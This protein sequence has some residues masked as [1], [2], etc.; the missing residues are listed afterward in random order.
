L[1]VPARHLE[2][3]SMRFPRICG[4]TLAVFVTVAAGAAMAQDLAEDSRP[5]SMFASTMKATVLDPTTYAPATVLYGSML[6]DWKSSQPFFAHGF[7]EANPRYTRNGLPYDVP[8]SYEAGKRQIL[9]DSLVTL[10]GMIAN[11]AISHLMERTLI[12]SH[13]EHRKLFRVLGVIQRVS[14]SAFI[15]YRLSAGHFQQWQKNQRLAAQLGY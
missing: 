3:E 10:P 1:A 13:P 4:L 2:D 9:K 7:V 6:L 11:N 12:R 14:L 5:A 8:I 15:S